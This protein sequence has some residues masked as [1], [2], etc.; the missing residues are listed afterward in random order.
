MGGAEGRAVGDAGGQVPFA[1]ER[2]GAPWEAPG[3]RVVGD[4]GDQVPL[5]EA[6]AGAPWEAPEGASRWRRRGSGR[7]DGRVAAHGHRRG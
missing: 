5:A 2:P 3:V 4:A 7:G 1:E 6:R